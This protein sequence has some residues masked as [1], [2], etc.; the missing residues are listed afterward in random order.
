MIETNAGTFSLALKV[1]MAMGPVFCTTVG[2]SHI[3]LEYIIAGSVLDR[4]A[5]AEH[6]AVQ[7]EVVVHNDLLC[8]AGALS[9]AEERGEYSAV[10]FSHRLEQSISRARNIHLPADLPPTARETLA[11]YLHPSLVQRLRDGQID[12]I[13]EHRKV[14]VLF[15]QFEG[16]DYDHDP[17]VG[18]KLQSYLAAVMRIVHRYDGYLNRVDMG[19]KGS[20]YLV[21]FGAPVMHED[22][23]ERALRCA[24]VL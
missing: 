17:H 14:T 18:A 13:N 11:S 19:D 5:E 4:C 15:V 20:K 2:D 9:I 23:E 3:Q 6:H 16:F 8:Y 12:L 10:A 21:L 22:D 24:L 7:G 1:G